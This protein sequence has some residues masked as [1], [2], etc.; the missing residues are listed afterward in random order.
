MRVTETLTF[1]AYSLDARFESK[2]PFRMGS[3]KQSCGDNIYFRGA[4]NGEWCQ[5]DSFHSQES[6]QTHVKHMNRDTGV[7]RVLISTDFVY[8]GGEG[9]KIPDVLH[10]QDGRRLCKRGIGRMCFDDPQLIRD[11]EDWVRGFGVNGF[12]GPPYEW[13]SLRG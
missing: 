7:N 1:E 6:G 2:K 11:L 13:I 5:R 12:Q 3:L 4:P 8:F 9:P 10:D